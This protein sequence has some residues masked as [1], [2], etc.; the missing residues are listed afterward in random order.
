M[1][2]VQRD[3][4]ESSEASSGG[5]GR[6]MRRELM[7]LLALSAI[8]LVV[9]W[10]AFDGLSRLAVRAITPEME[11]QWLGALM[12]SMDEWEPTG[13]AQIRRVEMIRDSMARLTAHPDA[14]KLDFRLIIINENSPNAFAIPGGVIGFT[15]GMVDALE[16]NEI[17]AAFVIA[18]ELGHFAHRDHLRGL[19][20]EIGSFAALQILFGGG[21]N[22]VFQTNDLMNLNYSRRQEE[23]A[24]AYAL[25]LL[26]D[27]YGHSKGADQLFEILSTSSELPDWAHMF[28][29]HPNPR[30]R[31]KRLRESIDSNK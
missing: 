26:I 14:P 17:A 5:G 27:V 21:G 25:H 7:A 13:E 29:T 4:G 19:I 6:G 9:I 11:S 15:R 3:L 30:D 10:A 1:K 22:L 16:D 31:M 23:A 28:S 12:P 2:F 20:R 8:T 18:H 24:D